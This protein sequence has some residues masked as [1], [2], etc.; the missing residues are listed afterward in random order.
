MEL[1]VDLERQ[2]IVDGEGREHT[3][4]IDARRRRCLLQGLDTIALT[5]RMTD[6]IARFEETHPR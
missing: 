6:R 2:V 1:T 4:A 5:L 3:F